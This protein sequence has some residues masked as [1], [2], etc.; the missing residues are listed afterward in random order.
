M[1][2]SLKNKVHFSQNARLS[3]SQN[4]SWKC[5]HMKVVTNMPISMPPYILASEPML[6]SFSSN[7]L[8][9]FGLSSITPRM[10]CI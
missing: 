4:T 7:V 3:Q 8:Q 10:S 2:S 6:L 1:P 5:P 9:L